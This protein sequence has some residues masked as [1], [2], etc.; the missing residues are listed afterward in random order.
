LSEKSVLKLLEL[1]VEP[2]LAKRLVGKAM[3]T[4]LEAKTVAEVVKIAYREF[5]SA[6]EADDSS[7][8]QSEND[9][10]NTSGYAA[11]KAGGAIG[12]DEW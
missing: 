6:S 8:N 12:G 3:A 10:R 1:G 2:V 5:L 4:H 9:L 11:L 7:D